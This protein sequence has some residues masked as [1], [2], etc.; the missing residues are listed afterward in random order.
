MAVVRCS[1]CGVEVP[2]QAELRYFLDGM[3]M[4]SNECMHAAGY[5]GNCGPWCACTGYAIKRRMLR[6]HRVQM[7]LMDEIIVQNGLDAELNQLAIEETGDVCFDL[8]WDS[9]MDEQSDAEDPEQ[10]LHAALADQSAMV[11]AVQGALE[12]RSVLLDMERARMELEDL[13]SRQLR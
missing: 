8:G 1:Q 5:R 13:R 4:C 11:Q 7:R 10:Q 12:C 3:R 2:L 9:E 6:D